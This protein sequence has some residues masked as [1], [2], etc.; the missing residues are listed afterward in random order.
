MKIIGGNLNSTDETVTTTKTINSLTATVLAAANPARLYL[1]VSLDAGLA[2]VEA[3]IREY[4]A[5]TDNNLDG[6]LL[7]RNTLANQSLYKSMY[8]TGGD[9]YVYTGEVSA[10]SVVGSF[11][12]KVIE[13]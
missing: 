8:E 7:I 4:P 10:I 12:L 5:A 1:R 11:D 6:E 3:F 2:N 13:G 9:G